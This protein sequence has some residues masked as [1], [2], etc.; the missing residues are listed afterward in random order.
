MTLVE[1]RSK[2]TQMVAYA[3]I[4]I[5]LASLG[6]GVGVWSAPV[7][8]F[9]ID[10]SGNLNV[11]G[12]NSNTLRVDALTS[13]RVPIAGTAG[14]LGDDADLRWTGGDTLTVANVS[15]SALYV[16]SKD[17]TNSV[18]NPEQ[19][20]SYVVW[21]N[22]ATGIVNARNGNTGEID[23]SGAVASTVINSAIN[24]V[25]GQGL[26]IIKGEL[27]ITSPIILKAR[28]AVRGLGHGGAGYGQGA[29]RFIVN[30][31]ISCVFNFNNTGAIQYLLNDISDIAVWKG[32]GSYQ[33]GFNLVN[34]GKMTLSNMA[35][36]NATDYAFYLEGCEGIKIIDSCEVFGGKDAVFMNVWNGEITIR[37]LHAR[38]MTAPIIFVQGNISTL[39][40]ED[41]DIFSST[42]HGIYITGNGGDTIDSLLFHGNNIHDNGQFGIAMGLTATY[43]GGEIYANR[44]VTN[45]WGSINDY[46]TGVNYFGNYGVNGV[47]ETRWNSAHL[48]A[49]N[50]TAWVV[51]GP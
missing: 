28:V 31:A 13:G 20:Y 11:A 2:R 7:T 22:T 37:D 12:I 18:T 38:T 26:V 43:T 3:L 46:V 19:G 14:L 29:T 5:M 23:F 9:G 15:T 41:S 4:G 21:N 51:I 24:A 6:Y 34:A 10:G 48:E 17:V 44:F 39:R 33:R 35:F 50:S 1:K 36:L 42:T 40:V 16:N 8:S 27:S 25:S 45:G 49:W 32:T 47:G 30:N